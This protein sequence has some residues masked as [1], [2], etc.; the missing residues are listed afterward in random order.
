MTQ[1]PLLAVPG[2]KKIRSNTAQVDK[3]VLKRR[4]NF[5]VWGA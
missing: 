5:S 3:T 1:F 4:G 2:I